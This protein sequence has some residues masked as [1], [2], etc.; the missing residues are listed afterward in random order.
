MGKLPPKPND[1]LSWVGAPEDFTE[2]EVFQVQT[3]L[4]EALFGPEGSRIPYVEKVS[5]VMLEMK[6]L[7]SSDLTEVM[8]YGPYL[9]KFRTKWMLQ[10]MAEWH[11]Q[12]QE[13]G[14]KPRDEVFWNLSVKAA[15]HPLLQ[16]SSLLPNHPSGQPPPA[17]RQH[18]EAS[19][20]GLCLTPA[21]VPSVVWGP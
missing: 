2:P 1:I 19:L 3:R 10:S 11:R 14:E 5:K 4:L 13:R 21:V 6:V 17:L 7:E 8:V 20:S 18:R 16:P 15:S 9:Y 12:R